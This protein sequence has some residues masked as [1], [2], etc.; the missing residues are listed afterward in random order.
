M[1]AEIDA[2]ADHYEDT[3]DRAGF[4]FPETKADSMKVNLRNLWSRMALTQA[5]V[6]MLHG[7]LRQ[8]VRWKQRGD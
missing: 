6:R 2:L 3:L 8:M 4:F 5:D 1:A 7:I